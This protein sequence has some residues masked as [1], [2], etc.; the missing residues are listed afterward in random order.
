MF[1]SKKLRLLGIA[2]LALPAIAVALF[3]SC[4]KTPPSIAKVEISGPPAPVCPPGPNFFEDVTDQS[5]IQ[6]TYRNGEER[7]YYAILS[8]LGGGG[9]FIDFDGDGK[10][11]IFVP[12]GGYYDPPLEKFKEQIRKVYNV[13]PFDPKDP[14][15]QNKPDPMEQ[16]LMRYWKEDVKKPDCKIPPPK[17]R[18]YPSKLYRNLGNFKFEDVTEQ[19]LGPA[20]DQPDVFTHGCA[21]CDYDR[22]GWPDLLVTGYGRVIL[23]HN[24]RDGKG[25][26]KLVDRTREAGLLGPNPEQKSKESGQLGEHFWS[27]SAAFCDLDGDGWPDLYLCQYVNWSWFNNPTCGGYTSKVTQDVCPPKQFDSRPHAV[28]R[29]K[30]DGTF[31]NVTQTCG[32]R[33]EPRA[34]NDY[35]KGLGVVIVDVDGDGKPDI[36]IAN[37]T[38][39]HFL[40]INKSTPGKILLEERGLSLGVARDHVGTANGGMGTWAGDWDGCGRPSLWV[41]NYES[42]F[43]GLYRSLLNNNHI[44]FTFHSM[45]VGLTVAGPNFVGFGTCFLDIE[46]SGWE[47]IAISN[48]HVIHYPARDNLRQQPLLFLNVQRETKKGPERYFVDA[49]SRGGSYF[50]ALH[51]GRGL[52]V[53]DLNNDGKPDLVFFNVDEPLRILRNV[54]QDNNHWLGVEL[55]AKDHR[56]L[57]GAKLTLEVGGR[58]LHRYLLGGGSYL[59][60]HDMRMVFGLGNE[61]KVGTLTVEWPSGES[62]IQTFA[63]N[64]LSIDQYNRLEQK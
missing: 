28:W 49:T 57:A 1:R 13:P 63:A 58:K 35:G 55:I 47:D 38:T 23:Y 62:K 48:G 54:S 16:A 15:N 11:D 45:A 31:E 30:G 51:R 59:S 33:I 6:F 56:H 17:I 53:G 18:G 64:D 25:G 34:D 7:G 14:N 44:S 37:D 20:K 60:A 26:R 32:L 4:N 43:N 21:V 2:L 46:H 19:V 50:Q 36:H 61:T 27:S 42:E 29:N 8:S 10:L 22:D 3:L 40:Y 24:E 39:D 41:T 9:A 5:G 52:A 12:G